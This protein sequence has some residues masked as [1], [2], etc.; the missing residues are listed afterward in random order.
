M[1]ANIHIF[2]VC[3]KNSK[4]VYYNCILVSN[5]KNTQIYAIVYLF[6]YSL[7][8][9]GVTSHNFNISIANKAIKLNY[10]FEPYKIEVK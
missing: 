6:M 2:F 9:N 10:T 4:N 8:T 7:Y 3:S 1:S 5:L